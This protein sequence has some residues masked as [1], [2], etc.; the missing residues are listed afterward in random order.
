MF[1]VRGSKGKLSEKDSCLE[2]L[3]VFLISVMVS[4]VLFMQGNAR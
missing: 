3:I 4:T 2:M 1:E